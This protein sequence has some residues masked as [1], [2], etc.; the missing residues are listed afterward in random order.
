MWK[1]KMYC[2]L[3]SIFSAHRF[4]RVYLTHLNWQPNLVAGKNCHNWPID[5]VRV[6]ICTSGK[7]TPCIFL[8]SADFSPYSVNCQSS[9]FS[10]WPT[11]VLRGLMRSRG[12]ESMDKP[13]KS[14]GRKKER[15]KEE[16]VKMA[17][18]PKYFQ[19]ILAANTTYIFWLLSVVCYNYQVIATKKCRILTDIFWTF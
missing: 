3:L 10:Q 6:L 8:A 7:L 19:C 16:D 9:H 13:W 12:R 17:R 4:A 5:G 15:R 1:S 18:V 14:E 11:F 2:N